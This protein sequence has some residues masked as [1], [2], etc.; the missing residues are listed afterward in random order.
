MNFF[1]TSEAIAQYV[2]HVGDRRSR[3]CL[4]ALIG[5]VE[6]DPARGRDVGLLE[7]SADP[8]ERRAAAAL[9]ANSLIDDAKVVLANVFRPQLRNEPYVLGAVI[10]TRRVPHHVQAD[11]TILLVG[12]VLRTDKFD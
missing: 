2:K 7:D 4:D 3:D 5:F 10:H 11:H 8:W 1:W 6:D 12:L 9:K